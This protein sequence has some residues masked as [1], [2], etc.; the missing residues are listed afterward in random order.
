MFLKSLQKSL[1]TKYFTIL[2]IST[3]LPL[4]FDLQPT[5]Y[6]KKLNFLNFYFVKYAWFWT[7]ILVFAMITVSKKELRKL[8]LIRL[9]STTAYWYLVTSFM[10]L[11]YIS[12]GTCKM[13][14]IASRMN[15]I[16][17]TYHEC[18]QDWSGF[19]ISGH[20]FILLHSSLVLV[21]ELRVLK[22]DFIVIQLFTG[23][24]LVLW[25]IMMIVTCLYFHP[26]SEVFVGFWFGILGWILVYV[27]PILVSPA[28]VQSCPASE[29]RAE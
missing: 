20:V 24:F 9:A 1:L 29:I 5:F 22:V 17:L 13:D 8:A 16:P 15:A 28:P 21:E 23:L 26:I 27:L 18:K 12:I 3:L 14:G 11:V 25:W 6:S 10:R 19:D 2:T 7:I 4:L